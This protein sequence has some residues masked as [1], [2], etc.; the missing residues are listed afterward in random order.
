MRNTLDDKF[1]RILEKCATSPCQIDNMLEERTVRFLITEKIDEKDI[2]EIT[3]KLKATGKVLDTLK[4]YADEL[5][6]QNELAPLYDYI[7]ALE[8]A[9]DKTDSELTNVSFETGAVSGFFGKKVTLPAIVAAAVKINTKAVDFGRGF[10]S[11]MTKIRNQLAP[12]LK[13]ANKEDTLR[14]AIEADAALDTETILKGFKDALIDD[15]GGT[16]FKK[17]GAFFSGTSFGK[18]AEIMK[19]P[20]LDVDMKALATKIADELLDAKLE[21]LLGQAP[22][23]V[24][25]Q[26]LVTDLADEMQDAEDAAEAAEDQAGGEDAKAPDEDKDDAPAGAYALSRNDL[27][28]I[29]TAMD[30][31][32]SA[33]K[34]Q[35]KALGS[36]LNQMLGKDVFA[37]HKTYNLQKIVK[38]SVEQQNVELRRWQRIA[39]I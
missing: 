12:R 31:A 33:K 39:G 37:E 34:S 3:S 23:P 16:L 13:D 27:K 7:N 38:T 2:N 10:L 30:K 19:T 11:A 32:K 6:L 21:N 26:T 17:V 20:G 18:E 35:T 1:S 25:D 28:A 24:P 14:A 36:A 29:K 15:L 22:P 8:G 4:N 5:Q 9:I